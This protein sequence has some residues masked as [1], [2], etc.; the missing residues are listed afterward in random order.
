M[1]GGAS[2]VTGRLSVRASTRLSMSVVRRGGMTRA[3]V[4]DE[5]GE[6]T[7]ETVVIS[8][9]YLILP[10]TVGPPSLADSVFV[11]FRLNS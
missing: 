6:R 1:A 10:F 4:C 11:N 3:R 2:K 9:L 5:I 7:Q 8:N